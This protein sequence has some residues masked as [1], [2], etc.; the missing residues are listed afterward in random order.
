L[1]TLY[2]IRHGQTKQN[3]LHLIQG[4]IDYPL[5]SV[6]EERIKEVAL[7]L[8][9]DNYHFDLIYSSPLKRAVESAKIIKDV[10]DIDSPIIIEDELIEREFGDAE[11]VPISEEIYNDI[12]NDKVNHMEKCLLIEKRM[13][14]ESLK[15][16]KENINKSVLIV[17]HS[18]AIKALLI[19]LDNKRTF[20]DTLDNASLTTLVYN[21]NKLEI[22]EVN[23]KLFEE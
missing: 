8:K 21:N 18:H 16:A 23:K 4:R 3:L 13:L 11:G 1:T 7:K 22:K 20:S 5:S 2:F 14:T 10:M 9:E 15:I 12:M 19:S 6:G 17:C